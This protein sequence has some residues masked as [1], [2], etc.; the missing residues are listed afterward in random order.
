[1]TFKLVLYHSVM[2]SQVEKLQSQ[3][4]TQAW[5]QHFH[6]FSKREMRFHNVRPKIS[7]TKDSILDSNRYYHL[8]FKV[9]C[10]N[11]M[12]CVVHFK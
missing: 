6:G 1:M 12:I 8:L 2:T 9:D 5:N 10:N 3:R 7:A 4:Y 11:N